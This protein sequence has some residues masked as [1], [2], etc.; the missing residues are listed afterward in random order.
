M[1]TCDEGNGALALSLAFFQ[2]IHI[3]AVTSVV[4]LLAHTFYTPGQERGLYVHGKLLLPSKA[5][6]WNNVLQY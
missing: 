2:M 1:R 5:D 6:L 3:G 4:E